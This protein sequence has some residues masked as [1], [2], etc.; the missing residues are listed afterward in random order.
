[1]YPGNELN[2]DLFKNLINKA[3]WPIYGD[4]KI[5]DEIFENNASCELDDSCPEESGKAF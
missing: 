5:L 1:M 2:I 3:Y 4:M